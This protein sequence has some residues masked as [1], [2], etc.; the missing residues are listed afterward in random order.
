MFSAN[1]QVI[2]ATG[3]WLSQELPSTNVYTLLQLLLSVFCIFLDGFLQKRRN[4]VHFE[5]DIKRLVFERRHPRIAGTVEVSRGQGTS[6]C[7]YGH[8]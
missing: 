4:N 1:V 6:R 3:R 7:K 8:Y 2:T 5:E